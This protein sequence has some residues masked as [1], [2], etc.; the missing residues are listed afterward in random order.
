MEQQVGPHPETW[1][2]KGAWSPGH[3]RVALSRAVGAAPGSVRLQ[4]SAGSRCSLCP[5]GDWPLHHAWSLRAAWELRRP[6]EGSQA[7]ERGPA[8]VPQQSR[9]RVTAV[10]TLVNVTIAVCSCASLRLPLPPC[11][12]TPAHPGSRLTSAHLSAQPP[13][14]QAVGQ[15]GPAHRDPPHLWT[16]RRGPACTGPGATA[17]GHTARGWCPRRPS[18]FWQRGQQPA[19][20]WGPLG[21]RSY[22]PLCPAS[23]PG[24]PPLAWGWLPGPLAPLGGGAGAEW[25]CVCPEREGDAWPGLKRPLRPQGLLCLPKELE[26]Q[27]ELRKSRVGGGRFRHGAGACTDPKPPLRA[28]G[29]LRP[30][31]CPAPSAP[32]PVLSPAPL[33][34]RFPCTASAVPCLSA[35]SL[36]RR[37]N[38]LLRA[39]LRAS[40]AGSSPRNALPS[41]P[42][43]A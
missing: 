43:S 2:E 28:W 20:W 17:G 12:P 6:N 33:P 11:P 19:Q 41:H 5:Q 40:P 18:W 39:P 32:S 13:P 4:T 25:R 27:L 8:R 29:S 10:L 1:L 38:W 37:D 26:R 34:A 22:Q 15:C 14:P 3:P 9:L 16:G 23:Q 7:A 21:S 24:G 31:P 42:L 30:G 35:H 36:L